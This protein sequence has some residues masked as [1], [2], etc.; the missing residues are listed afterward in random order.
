VRA[1]TI[2]NTLNPADPQPDY[3]IS[4]TYATF[5]EYAKALQY[6]ESAVIDS[7]GDAT[8]RGNLGV[9]YYRNFDWDNAVKQLGLAIFGGTTEEGV[10]VT[11]IPLSN[12]SRVGEIYFTF[13]LALARTNQCGQALQIVQQLQAG[14]PSDDITV[15]ATNR[16]I[17]LC[18]E[19]LD[20]PEATPA[21]TETN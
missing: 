12:N 16:I 2:A 6:A 13:G 3:L 15:D 17:E 9:M 14:G 20:N 11:G 8:M 7:P 18:Q 5:G 4:R 21:P 10:E 19:N 1:Y